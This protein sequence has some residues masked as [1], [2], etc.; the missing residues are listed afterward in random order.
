VI[1][2]PDRIAERR[3]LLKLAI[4]LLAQLKPREVLAVLLWLEDQPLPDCH[5][6][7][8]HATVGRALA[9]LRSAWL[10]H[11]RGARS[12]ARRLY[13]SEA[14]ALARGRRLPARP[15]PARMPD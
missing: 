6:D 8:T 10:R 4:T 12:E 15:R 1:D 9:N 14:R 13:R 2:R 11:D 5:R 3:E 7:T